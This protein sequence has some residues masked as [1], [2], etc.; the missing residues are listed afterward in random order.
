MSRSAAE[1]LYP[2]EV[3][4][5]HSTGVCEDVGQDRDTALGEDRVGGERR[6][7][8]RGLGDD[9]GLDA[10]RVVDRDLILVRS[11]N[12]DVAVELEQLLVRDPLF[13]R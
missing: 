2:L 8:V 4:D 10:R 12:Q 7:A 1:V 9:G 3:R 13:R 11:Q 5:R 6:G